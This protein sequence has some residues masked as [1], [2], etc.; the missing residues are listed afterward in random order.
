MSARVGPYG[1]KVLW[2]LRVHEERHV[3]ARE[4]RHRA[5][6]LRL[7]D[8]RKLVHARRHEEALEA[9][10]ASIDERVEL[11]VV[12]R[13]D[14][15]P[16]PDIDVTLSA[17]CRS[18]RLERRDARRRRNAVE[19]HV[20]ERRDAAR[21]RRA[22]GGIKAFPL[23]AS[24]FVDVDVCV[25]DARRNDEIADVDGL[26]SVDGFVVRANAR[27]DAVL[28]LDR[29]RPLTVRQHDASAANQHFSGW[30]A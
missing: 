24:R 29:G 26:G 28:D 25:D 10:D 17:R 19:R 30:R 20:D 22:R 11:I 27:D 9:A 7:A 8:T 3:A 1:T 12:S 6:Q 4:Y 2:Q 15:A 23:G 13:H 18:L 5:P 14:A 16:E 21:R